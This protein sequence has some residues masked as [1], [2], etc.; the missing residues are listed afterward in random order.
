MTRAVDFDISPKQATMDYSSNIIDPDHPAET[1]PWGSSPAASP[2]H[3][4]TSFGPP[5]GEA[6]AS[7]TPFNQNQP[8]NGS[9]SGLGENRPA[10]GAAVGENGAIDSRPNTADS[11]LS[12]ADQPNMLPGQQVPQPQQ[13]SQSQYAQDSQRYPPA[14]RQTSRGPGP[15]Y[16]LQAKIT[17]LERPG[18]KDPI[19]R[20]DIYVSSRAGWLFCFQF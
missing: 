9:Y 17:G 16:K 5:S 8:S 18:R 19:L 20:F 6:P 7:P 4:R 11:V 14:P 2:E 1:S 10:A 13:Y 12:E 3:S 15:Q